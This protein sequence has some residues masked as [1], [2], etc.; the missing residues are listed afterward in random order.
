MHFIGELSNHDRE[1]SL[2]SGKRPIQIDMEQLA[3]KQQELMGW[4]EELI[5]AFRGPMDVDAVQKVK[6]LQDTIRTQY[7]RHQFEYRDHLKGT[8]ASSLLPK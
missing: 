2:Q 6:I 1:E 4:A 3:A 8:R 7:E 5:T